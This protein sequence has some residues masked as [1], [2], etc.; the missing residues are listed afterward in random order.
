M[1]LLSLADDF[2]RQHMDDT[3]SNPKSNPIDKIFRQM[4]L[5]IPSL[6]TE[7]ADLESASAVR[8]TF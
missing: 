2:N 8:I 5:S 7:I 6:N 3:A 4:Y 1:S